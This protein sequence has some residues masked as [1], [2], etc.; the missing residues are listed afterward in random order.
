MPYAPS[1]DGPRIVEVS[2]IEARAGFL[3][4]FVRRFFIFSSVSCALCKSA[5][6]QHRQFSLFFVAN[7]IEN[8]HYTTMSE[9]MLS[10]RQKNLSVLFYSMRPI[11][12]L[13]ADNARQSLRVTACTS[14]RRQSDAGHASDEAS[15]VSRSRAHGTQLISPTSSA[16]PRGSAMVGDKWPLCIM[17]H[18]V[19]SKF[20]VFALLWSARKRTGMENPLP[21]RWLRSRHGCLC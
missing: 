18:R 8:S 10:N 19:I 6:T 15:D 4:F 12:D 3:V 9:L 1:G 17:V 13:S 21:S 20:V 16:R 7:R 14:G 11:S 5:A 2:T